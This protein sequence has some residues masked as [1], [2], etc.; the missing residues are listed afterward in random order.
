MAQNEYTFRFRGRRQIRSAFV[1]VVLVTISVR[2]T[3]AWQSSTSSMVMMAASD[4][5]SSYHRYQPPVKTSVM[6]NLMQGRLV[7]SVGGNGGGNSNGGADVGPSGSMSSSPGGSSTSRSSTA[8][9][10]FVGAIPMTSP[11]FEQ[12]M[13]D[14]VLGTPQLQ[15]RRNTGTSTVQNRLRHRPHNVQLIE[16]LQQ[17]KSV[18]GDERHKIVAVR[19]YATYCKVCFYNSIFQ[20]LVLVKLKKVDPFFPP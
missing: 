15:Q 1:V 20:P 2:T 3:F 4:T 12:R 18:V 14:L 16:T 8:Q 5:G 11:T 17:Y 13:R 6:K 10:A 19:F 9:A 7:K